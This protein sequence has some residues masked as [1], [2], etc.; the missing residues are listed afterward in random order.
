[1]PHFTASPIPTPQAVLR[2]YDGSSISKTDRLSRGTPDDRYG[3]ASLVPVG[4]K[5]LN[6]GRNQSPTALDGHG[7]DEYRARRADRPFFVPYLDR[8]TI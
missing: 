2:A 1:M 3:L 6:S 7:K 8:Y 4:R 5:V